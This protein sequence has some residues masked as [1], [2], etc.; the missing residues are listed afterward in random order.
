MQNEKKR[1]T[2]ELASKQGAK[3]TL[4]K[5]IGDLNKQMDALNREIE[6]LANNLEVLEGDIYVKCLE[7]NVQTC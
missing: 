1:L 5:Q 7:L 4:G 2:T 6:L 3:E